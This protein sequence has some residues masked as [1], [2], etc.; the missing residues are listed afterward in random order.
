MSKHPFIE[1]AELREDLLR[2]QR[3]HDRR[4]TGVV[5]IAGGEAAE[6][7]L[8]DEAKRLRYL[9]RLDREQ[10]TWPQ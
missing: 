4:G 2:T 7:R 8:R 9:A 10:G 6:A 5:I 3:Q 1:E